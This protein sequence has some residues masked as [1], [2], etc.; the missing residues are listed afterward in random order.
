MEYRQFGRTGVAISAIGFGCWEISGTYGPI[1]AAQFDQAVQRALDAGINCF[2]TAEAYGMGISEQALARAL[3]GEGV[4]VVFIEI[5]EYLL[6]ARYQSVPAI[7][8]SSS[9]AFPSLSHA[10][11]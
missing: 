6:Y 5:A 4:E 10:G 8:N 3:V 9:R 7:V 11:A 2:D 1:D